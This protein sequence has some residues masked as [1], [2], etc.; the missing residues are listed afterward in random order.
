VQ[1]ARL[2]QEYDKLQTLL[3]QPGHRQQIRLLPAFPQS[4]F[5]PSL[6]C[7]V[8]AKQQTAP[9]HVKE[10]QGSSKYQREDAYRHD[11]VSLLTL[12]QIGKIIIIIIII[13][14]S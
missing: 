13:I 8:L 4:L 5:L 1:V 11:F 7:N 3:P 9:S 10:N 12:Q 6:K 14:I 2:S